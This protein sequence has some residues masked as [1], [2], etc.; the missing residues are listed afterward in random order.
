MKDDTI[1]LASNSP[2]R[3]QLLKQAGF[4][5]RVEPT[6]VEE[7]IRFSDPYSCVADIAR[8]KMHSYLERTPHPSHPVLTVDTM[9]FF[10][11]R[12]IGKP[13]DRE[14]A[15]AMLTRFS[16]TSH[17]VYSSA[18]IHIPGNHDEHSVTRAATITFHRLEDEEITTYL[19]ENEWIG[20][21][22]GYRI[23][24]RGISLISSLEG[25]YL[26]V[27]GLPLIDIFGILRKQSK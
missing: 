8:Q 7:V 22:G 24:G 11:G 19:A 3:Y 25:D 9:I 20:A 26:T 6:H 15:Y 21:A 17:S 27:M 10:D 5:V 14:E 1:I 23:Q 16:G 18:C 2:A 13:A 4:T 12:I